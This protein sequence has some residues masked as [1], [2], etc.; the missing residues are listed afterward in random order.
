MDETNSHLS[1]FN[2]STI[3]PRS[4]ISLLVFRRHGS[5]SSTKRRIPH[6]PN[7]KFALVAKI[8]LADR[9]EPMLQGPIFSLYL[10]A[11]FTL[12]LL[13]F[14]P[15]AWPS[16]RGGLHVLDCPMGLL[17]G[18]PPPSPDLK[19]RSAAYPNHPF[20]LLA[21][22]LSSIWSLEVVDRSAL[23]LF[24]SEIGDSMEARRR[25]EAAV[26]NFLGALQH[27]RLG[28]VKVYA[29]AASGYSL[30]KISEDISLYG[31]TAVFPWAIHMLTAMTPNCVELDATFKILKPYILKIL[32]LIF[33]NESITIAIAVF[34]T[35]TTESYQ[36]LYSHVEAI[37]GHAGVGT[38]V[39]S[40]L[41][42]VSDQ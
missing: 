4:S 6:T 27:I 36:L 18:L 23:A 15:E 34:P 2:P 31:L 26:H 35:E 42:L 32:H 41:P 10:D 25:R 22:R 17:L 14:K 13:Y 19:S 8:G 11:T 29:S 16:G 21:R 1:L 40:K 5:R 20:I 24:P 38:E 37:L 28:S 12:M 7:L 33:A 3:A 39:L 9:C 30:K